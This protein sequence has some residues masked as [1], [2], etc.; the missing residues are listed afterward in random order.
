MS[1]YG[2]LIQAL[3]V[4][5]NVKEKRHGIKTLSNDDCRKYAALAIA[6]L[7]CSVGAH[8]QL[9]EEDV[10]RHLI[11]ILYSEEVQEV[12]VYVINA[13]GNFAC[14]PIMWQQMHQFKAL[15]AVVSTLRNMEREEIKINALFCI[16]NMTADPA[17]RHEMLRIKLHEVVWGQINHP[18]FLIMQYSL[19]VLR[20]MAVEPQAQ[21]VLPKIGL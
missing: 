6:N 20:G 4:L 16:A 2:E 9:L 7:S 10:L 14:S 21:D 12:L 5:K 17:Q 8:Q 15:D 18:N 1:S 3:G 19:A 13:L 11:P